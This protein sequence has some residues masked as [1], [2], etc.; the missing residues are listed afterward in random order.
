MTNTEL[1]DKI[2]AL[3]EKQDL[4]GLG[5]TVW[6]EVETVTR[7]LRNEAR[8]REALGDW[9]AAKDALEEFERENPNNSTSRWDALFY[10]LDWAESSARQA[11]EA[12]NAK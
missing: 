2:D 8:M 4:E 9:I 12:T 11:L 10:A 3:A 5:F 1:A 6:N 7:A